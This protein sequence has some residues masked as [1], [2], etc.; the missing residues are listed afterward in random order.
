MSQARDIRRAAFQALFELDARGEA[1]AETVRALL[2]AALETGADLA[3]LLGDLRRRKPFLFRQPSRPVTAAQAPA[4]PEAP[5]TTLP[6]LA[7]EAQ[8]RGD[9]PSLLRYLRARRER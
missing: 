1:D 8:R 7:R 4:R 9:R 5:P 2:G 3:N 6:D